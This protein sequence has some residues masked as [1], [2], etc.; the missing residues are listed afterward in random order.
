MALEAGVP[1]V[2]I[3][4][5][6][7]P[8][9]GL[10]DDELVA[11]TRDPRVFVEHCLAVHTI[12]GIPLEQFAASIVATGPEQVVVSSDFG[13]VISGPFPVATHAYATRLLTLLGDRIARDAFIA[14]FSGNGR[15]ALGLAPS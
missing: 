9:V 4:H 7:Y 2:L 11:L 1:G 14:L 15:R 10:S 6:H 5:P 13:Q 12:E 3:T 8:S